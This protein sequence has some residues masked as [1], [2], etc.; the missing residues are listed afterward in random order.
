MNET[1]RGEIQEFQAREVRLLQNGRYD[2]WLQLF[3]DDVRYW[4]PIV[5][6]G[7]TREES[8]SGEADLAYFDD[9]LETLRL[10]VKRLSSKFAWVEIPPS[11]VRYFLQITQ[12]EPKDGQSEILVRTNFLTYQTRLE[13]EENFFVGEREDVLRRVQGEWKISARRVIVDRNILPGKNLS[14]FL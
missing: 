2:E 1:V 9:T 3:T 13:K 11:R 4:M 5:A 8:V 7:E 10:R 14:I 6:V 12:I